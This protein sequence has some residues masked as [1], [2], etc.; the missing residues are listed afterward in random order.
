MSKLPRRSFSEFY[1]PSPN[2]PK[3]DDDDDEYVDDATDA[4]RRSKNVNRILSAA[5]I[6]VE[7]D[8]HIENDDND[9]PDVE[10]DEDGESDVN[11]PSIRG[12]QVFAY[13]NSSVP[14]PCSLL[15]SH[16]GQTIYPRR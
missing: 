4:M 7:A 16:T 3:N 11:G 13:V 5:N 6:E 9:S 12:E 15:T 10:S 1:D 8:Y 14:A 2:D